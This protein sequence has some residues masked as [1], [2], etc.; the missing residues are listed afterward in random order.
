M[1]LGD[2]FVCRENPSF[3][4]TQ[5]SGFPSSPVAYISPFGASLIHLLGVVYGLILRASR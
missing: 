5:K 2:S 3:Y 4:L 1:L